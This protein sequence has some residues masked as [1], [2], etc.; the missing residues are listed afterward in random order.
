MRAN[1]MCV[2]A[3]SPR[4]ARRLWKQTGAHRGVR[5]S[6]RRCSH[7]RAK[8]WSERGDLNSRPLA[9]ELGALML[10]IDDRLCCRKAAHQGG[11]DLV[12]SKK[13]TGVRTGRWYDEASSTKRLSRDNGVAKRLPRL[14]RSPNRSAQNRRIRVPGLNLGRAIMLP[15]DC[16]SAGAHPIA[17]GIAQAP[18][19]GR[20]YHEGTGGHCPFP[21]DCVRHDNIRRIR[22]AP[23]AGSARPKGSPWTG[24]P[25]SPSGPSVRHRN[26][27]SGS[28]QAAR[29][30]QPDL[31]Q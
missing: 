24:T 27:S 10:A 22:S 25:P 16:N 23:A 7:L 30:V 5:K 3:M 9:R 18:R 19:A 31:T 17:R 26:S 28:A 6:V 12:W 1:G 15:L 13:W 21:D 20:P 8:C 11:G 14:P 29:A 4:S 2:A